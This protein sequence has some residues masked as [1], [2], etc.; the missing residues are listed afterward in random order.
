MTSIPVTH[1]AFTAPT[2]KASKDDVFIGEKYSF[3]STPITEAEYKA[4]IDYKSYFR[5]MGVPYLDSERFHLAA[6]KRDISGAI[7]AIKPHFREPECIKNL[8]YIKYHLE[9]AVERVR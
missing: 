2:I 4:K 5:L 1:R 3:D 7:R 9:N 6:L 8:R